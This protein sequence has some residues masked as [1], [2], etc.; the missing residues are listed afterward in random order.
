MFCKLFFYLLNF[1]VNAIGE[2]IEWRMLGKNEKGKVNQ[3]SCEG[4]V[5]KIFHLLFAKD[6][7]SVAS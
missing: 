7:S 5:G 2:T 1:F 4:N 6:Q 3:F